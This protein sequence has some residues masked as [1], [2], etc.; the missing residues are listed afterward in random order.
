MQTTT[1]FHNRIRG[2]K[3]TTMNFI[4]ALLR[5]FFKKGLDKKWVDK[6][7]DKLVD[8]LLFEELLSNQR[9]ATEIEMFVLLCWRW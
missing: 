3:P 6:L 4:D 1:I 8:L 7:L 5:N 9:K 2:I